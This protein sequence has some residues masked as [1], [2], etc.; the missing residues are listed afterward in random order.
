ME[1]VIAKF[2]QEF[3]QGKMNRRQLIQSLAFLATAAAAASPKPAAAA[4]GKVL[5]AINLNHISYT[6]ADY[7]RTR[8]WYAELFGM[9]VLEDNHKNRAVLAVG[10]SHIDI[11]TGPSAPLIDHICFTIADWDKIRGCP[12]SGGCEY[13]PP[14]DWTPEVV[15]R[16]QKAFTIAEWQNVG[17]G[18][19]EDLKRRNIKFKSA[20]QVSFHILDPDGYEVQ[21]GGVN[22]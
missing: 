19:G 22:Q 18:V 20:N 15:E 11:R 21:I 2:L 14:E 9:K 4:E 16:M 13:V 5:K 10:E 17:G 12:K 8:D 3:E 7:A 1:Q 6:G